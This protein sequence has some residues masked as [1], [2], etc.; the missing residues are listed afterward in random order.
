MI[1]PKTTGGHSSWPSGDMTI[2]P[3][4][5]GQP[6]WQGAQ[7]QSEG[8]RWTVW[9]AAPLGAVRTLSAGTWPPLQEIGS[10]CSQPLRVGWNCGWLGQEG[11]YSEA[12][13]ALRD[14]APSSGI[15]PGQQ[16]KPVWLTRGEEIAW[17]R[18]QVPQ[19][20]PATQK[21]GLPRQPQWTSERRAQLR[22][23]ESPNS[24]QPHG[25]ASKS[26]VKYDFY[27]LRQ[28]SH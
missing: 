8:Q 20:I 9:K 21:K 18:S 12:S 22:I 11:L 23:R 17:R 6:G 1:L 13:E 28:L 25:R 19:Q 14:S 16:S 24:A 5:L 27:A 3:H 2:R 15:W 10:L 26:R 7:R 4:P